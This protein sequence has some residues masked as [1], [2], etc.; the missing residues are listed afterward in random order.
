MTHIQKLALVP[1]EEW[2]KI[3]PKT[4]NG[5]M[6]IHK[7]AAHQVGRGIQVIQAPEMTHQITPTA[8][9]ANH[10]K[11]KMTTLPTPSIPPKTQTLKV[12]RTKTEKLQGLRVDMF[13]PKY[14]KGALKIWKLL[15][16]KGNVNITPH[17]EMIVQDK[18]IPDSNIVS[19]IEHAL[20]KKIV[21]KLQG[22]QKFYKILK[23][24]NAPDSLIKNKYY[25]EILTA[26]DVLSK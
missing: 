5:R 14:R 23:R 24:L 15:H 4:Q 13:S 8:E 20:N 6:M 9:A 1:L 16:V 26:H 3:R 12:K 18:R 21:K 7:T 10:P 19:L 22:Q 2:E 11:A 25:K 17:M